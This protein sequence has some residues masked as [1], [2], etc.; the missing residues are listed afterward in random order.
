MILQTIRFRVPKKRE[1]AM[2]AFMRQEAR[3]L[4]RRVPACRAAYFLGTASTSLGA[5]PARKGPKRAGEY[6][7]VTLWTSEAAR[8]RAMRRKDWRE[9]AR[10][11]EEA[12]FFA[13]KPQARHYKVLL[14]K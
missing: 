2:V 14:K 4:L 6:M 3:R 8:K 10:Q 5:G 1:R 11:E 7:W 9:V 13:G 12:G